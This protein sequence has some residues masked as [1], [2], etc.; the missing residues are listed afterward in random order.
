[1][2]TNLKTNKK[3]VVI[4]TKLDIILKTKNIFDF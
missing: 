2:E 3:L 4:V 1:M